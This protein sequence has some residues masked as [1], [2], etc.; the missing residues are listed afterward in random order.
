MIASV[1]RTAPFNRIPLNQ[2]LPPTSG[3]GYVEGLE[4][5]TLGRRIRNVRLSHIAPHCITLFAHGQRLQR[6]LRML[7]F[8]K[9]ITLIIHPATKPNAKPTTTYNRYNRYNYATLIKIK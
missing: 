2:P 6:L 8:Q 3:C 7:R 5:T 4:P 1:T 9:S